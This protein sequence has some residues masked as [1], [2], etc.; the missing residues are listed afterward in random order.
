MNGAVN[1]TLVA[2]A[3]GTWPM[4]KKKKQEEVSSIRMCVSR[5]AGLYA[6]GRA[7]QQPS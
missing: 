4:A 2:S 7:P 1:P 6:S 5:G 3:T